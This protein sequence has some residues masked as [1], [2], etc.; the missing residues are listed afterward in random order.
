MVTTNLE[1]Y[2][3]IVVEKWLFPGFNARIGALA[4]PV[5]NVHVVFFG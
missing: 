1:P 4:L 2:L 3:I 5:N